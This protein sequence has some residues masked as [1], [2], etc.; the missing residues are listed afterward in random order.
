MEQQNSRRTPGDRMVGDVSTQ[1]TDRLNT[2]ILSE[3]IGRVWSEGSGMS[4]PPGRSD[5]GSK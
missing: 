3:N 1:P 4:L 2:C 5:T